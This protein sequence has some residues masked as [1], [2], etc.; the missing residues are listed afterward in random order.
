MEDAYLR[1]RASDVRD[2]GRCVLMHLQNL[3]AARSKLLF[4]GCR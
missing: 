3:T 2:L 4:I 1:E